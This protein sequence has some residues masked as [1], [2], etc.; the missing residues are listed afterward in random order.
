ML[1]MSAG[2]SAW[3]TANSEQFEGFAQV[4]LDTMAHPHSYV[5]K[6]FVED[7]DLLVMKESKSFSGKYANGEVFYCKKFIFLNIKLNHCAFKTSDLNLYIKCYILEELPL[8]ILIGSKDI[9]DYDLYD[10]IKDIHSSIF[11]SKKVFSTWSAEDIDKEIELQ[12]QNEVY[13]AALTN[14]IDEDLWKRLAQTT[15]L[16]EMKRAAL[17]ALIE[18]YDDLFDDEVRP[19]PARVSKIT[20][21]LKPQEEMG[22]AFQQPMRR[23]PTAYLVEIRKQ[24]EKMLQLGVIR[25]SRCRH[26][27]QIHLAKRADG[28]LR[29]CIDYKIL[30]AITEV[31]YTPL[32]DIQTIMQ[33]LNGKFLFAKMDL[34]A[35]FHQIEIDEDSKKFTAFRGPDHIYEFNRCP[36][37]LINASS[38]F[39]FVIQH[40]VLAGLIN[41]IC[42]CYID[43]IIVF[44]TAEDFLDN[45]E[46]VFERL[47]EHNIVLKKSKCVFGVTK[48]KYLGHTLSGQGMEIGEDN[49][50]LFDNMVKPETVTQLRSLLGVYSYFRAF[51][52][53]QYANTVSCLYDMCKGPKRKKLEWNATRDAA[54]ERARSLIRSASKLYFLQADG[55]IRLYTD[56]SLYGF[57]GYLAQVQLVPNADGTI[58][59]VERPIYFYSKAFTKQQYRW[60]TSDKECHAI[61]YGVKYLHH[62]IANREVHIFTDH[63]AIAVAAHTSLSASPKIQ[64]MRQELS[65]YNLQYHYIRGEDNVVADALSRLVGKDIGLGDEIED[66]ELDDFEKDLEERLTDL[67][68]I[69]LVY[70]G[71]KISKEEAQRRIKKY[72]GELGHWGLGSTIARITA[73]GEHWKGMRN[74][75]K[76]YIDSCE[77]C[78]R[79]KP[80]S[81]VRV[82]A[83]Q[84]SLSYYSPNE[85]W[86]MDVYHY[87]EDAYGFKHVLVIIDLF[88]RYLTLVP[89][90]TL[91]SE[92]II[93]HL[94]KIFNNDGKPDTIIADLGTNLAAADT[95]AVQ[96][97]LNIHSIFAPPRSKQHNG[98]AERVIDEVRSQ[99]SILLEELQLKGAS[100]SWSNQIPLVQRLHNIRIHEITGIAPAELKF[101][102]PRGLMQTFRGNSYEELLQHAREG[103]A[104]SMEKK[105]FNSKDSNE[106]KLRE[107]DYVWRL[108]PSHTKMDPLSKR[109]LGPYLVLERDGTKALLDDGSSK[110]QFVA[111]KELV[112]H[113]RRDE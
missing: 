99:M 49:Q 3:C 20:I 10:R 94:W 4:A 113:R 21:K 87:D 92:E 85:A 111:L 29:F 101:Q 74:Q 19:I 112:L 31:V 64:R 65:T 77:H 51:L 68:M 23:Q 93:W 90:K 70:A 102:D 66:R 57:G 41:K 89:L 56:A 108:N 46:K 50:A 44:G 36:F 28:G 15:E 107:G 75:L 33:F 13:L 95:T 2:N 91:T 40:D 25:I 76:R 97:F 42:F 62:M 84:F 72:H 5:S 82:H 88:H 109:R 47:R 78:I 22:R 55:E 100:D 32:P 35:G 71:D 73:N 39:Q 67:K 1:F 45:L 69:A 30:N 81:G 98:V 12:D 60:S 8:D 27:S 26:Y 106:H 43:D 38:H 79:N 59:E 24:I 16:E 54:Y 58:S 80:N 86:A 48:L 103:I 34:S 7:N 37:G 105:F 61:Y 96:R 110:K 83:E 6:A 14:E 9:Y 53:S 17:D 104:M 63:R 18:K 11:H 52:G